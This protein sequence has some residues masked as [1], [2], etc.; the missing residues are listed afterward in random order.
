MTDHVEGCSA[1]LI[2][3][4]S[5]RTPTVVE[6]VSLNLYPPYN[7]VEPTGSVCAWVLDPLTP[8]SGE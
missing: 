6:D 2:Y 7:T 4:G 5:L 1:V 8:V 3:Y